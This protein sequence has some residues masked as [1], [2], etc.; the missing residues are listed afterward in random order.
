VKF[1]GMTSEE[2]DGQNMSLYAVRQDILM[3]E[4]EQI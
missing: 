2:I 3:H 4:T 1:G